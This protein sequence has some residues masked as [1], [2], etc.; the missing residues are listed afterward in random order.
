MTLVKANKPPVKAKRKAKR[1]EG[2]KYEGEYE[3]LFTDDEETARKPPTKPTKPEKETKPQK[4]TTSEGHQGIGL[5]S[6]GPT[7]YPDT[8]SESDIDIV[9]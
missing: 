9:H 1:K 8:D 5:V 2:G 4:P 6:L 7:L 3:G